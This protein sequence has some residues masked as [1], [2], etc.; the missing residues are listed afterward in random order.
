MA[1]AT[2]GAFVAGLAGT[3]H[4]AELPAFT[5]SEVAP[6]RVYELTVTAE[7]EDSTDY[8]TWTLFRFMVHGGGP[9]SDHNNVNLRLREY[10][11]LVYSYNSP[12]SLEFNRWYAVRPST[13]V[14]TELRGPGGSRDHRTNAELSVE[15]IFD[16]PGIS[17]VSCTAKARSR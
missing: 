13:T 10:G 15:A 17:D 14:R 8:R 2:A 12:D 3:A 1:V 4:A 11:D 5:C 7:Y 6:P 9:D 16:R